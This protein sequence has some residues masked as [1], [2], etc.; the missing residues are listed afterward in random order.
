MNSSMSV[1]ERA[2]VDRASTIPASVD[3][4]RIARCI[5]AAEP[6]DEDELRA[7]VAAAQEAGDADLAFFL[8]AWSAEKIAAWRIA[9]G[10]LG[11]DEVMARIS[12]RHED[13]GTIHS[14]DDR[15]SAVSEYQAL[16]DEILI[17]TL[18]EFRE[19]EVVVA[20]SGRRDEYARRWAAGMQKLAGAYPDLARN[21]QAVAFPHG[22]IPRDAPFTSTLAPAGLALAG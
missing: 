9:A 16:A 18:N 22:R 20:Y 10:D 3:L 17:D 12:V 19:F 6:A 5:F 2:V 7:F 11:I 14:C 1:A 21:S 4:R 13:A 8:I 15:R